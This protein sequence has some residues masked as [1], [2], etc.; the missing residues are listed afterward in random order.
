MP[1]AILFLF[2]FKLVGALAI[3]PGGV[4]ISIKK[5]QDYQLKRLVKKAFIKIFK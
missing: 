4:M 2:G 1:G 5:I 3:Y